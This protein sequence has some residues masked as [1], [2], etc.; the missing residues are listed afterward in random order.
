[1]GYQEITIKEFKE[2]FIKILA[3]DWA[4]F[5]AGK[6]DDFNTMTVS[7]GGIGYLWN[8]PVATIYVRPSRYT[9]EFIERNSEMTLSFFGG[10]KK[11]A[12]A[13]CGKISGR[14]GNK[15]EKAGLVPLFLED[16]V[17]FEDAKI[18]ITG[19][20]LQS[21]KMILDNV[22]DERVLDCYKNGDIHDIFVYQIKRILI[23]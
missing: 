16:G 19:S 9:H 7:W 13:V 15:H 23:A 18:I 6:K 10:E 12:L 17:S 1:M 11:N 20:L 4:L 8:L 21:Q 5:T 3:D 22:T 14:E 2:S